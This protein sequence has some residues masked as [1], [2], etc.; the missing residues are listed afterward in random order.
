MWLRL[1]GGLGLFLGSLTVGWWLNR[2]GRLNERRA[3]QIVRFLVMGTSPVVLCLLFWR[4]NLRSPAPWLL[5]FLGATIAFATLIPAWLYAKRAKLPD[6]QVGSFLTCAFFSNVGYLGA[7][8]AFALF[9]E[10]AY[11]LCM[12]YL[13]YF[14]PCFYT[15]G[16]W[17]AAS[18]GGDTERSGL[19]IAFSDRLRFFPFIG[20]L[21]GMALSFSGVPRPVLLERLNH[22]LIPTDTALYLMAIG[23]QLRFESPRPWLRSCLAMSAMKFIYSPLIAW[24]LITLFHLHGLP[25]VIVLLEASTPVAVS[26]LVLPMLFGLDRRLSNALWLVT[27]VVS[28]PWLL[29]VIPVLQRIY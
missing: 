11:G 14:T 9:G 21:A 19:G 10:A 16:F 29:L 23:S 22:L 25:R 8:T 27:T 24:A 18:C 13:M 1:S 2:L 4:M 6:P 7:F 26:P 3:S 20:I 5:P 12:L 15:V 17:I 28:I